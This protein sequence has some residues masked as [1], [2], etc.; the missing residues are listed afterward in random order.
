MCVFFDNETD[1]H[2]EILVAMTSD[3]GLELLARYC[4]EYNTHLVTS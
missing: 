2:L 1:F 3:H 4:F